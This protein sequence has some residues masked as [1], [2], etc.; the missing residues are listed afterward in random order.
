MKNFAPTVENALLAQENNYLE[1][2]VQKLLISEGNDV[3]ANEISQ[4]SAIL[5]EIINTPLVLLK[6]IEGPE[7]DVALRLPLDLF[8]KNVSKL[9]KLIK[10]GY[11]PAPLIVTDYWNYLEIADGNHRHEALLRNG[12]NSYWTIFLIK[13]PTGKKYFQEE[14]KT[15]IENLI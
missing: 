2:W 14:F 10:E 6:K 5:A 7:E 12:I 4:Q 11:K 13:H 1:E 8:E 15:Q 9:T 3:L